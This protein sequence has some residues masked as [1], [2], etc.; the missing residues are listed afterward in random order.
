MC[1]K[2]ANLL[3]HTHYI[4]CVVNFFQKA[5][6]L[7]NFEFAT[8]KAWERP[9][10]TECAINE[11]LPGSDVMGLPTFAILDSS[12]Q[13]VRECNLVKIQMLNHKSV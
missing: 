12:N 1:Y 8:P 3:P 6:L 9:G 13:A 11:L 10:Q 7:L 2:A 5:K 4:V